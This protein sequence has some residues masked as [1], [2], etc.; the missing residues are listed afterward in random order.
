MAQKVDVHSTC[1][2]IV[3][4]VLHRINSW[5]PL[6]VYTLRWEMA[7]AAF[8]QVQLSTCVG[9]GAIL[10]LSFPRMRESSPA[11]VA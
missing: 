11:E 9:C 8:A 5:C 1:I 7:Q 3:L 10:S 6:M 4:Q 2:D